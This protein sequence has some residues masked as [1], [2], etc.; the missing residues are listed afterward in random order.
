MEKYQQF[1]VEGNSILFCSGKDVCRY[2]VNV[3]TFLDH[4][5]MYATFDSERIKSICRYLLAYI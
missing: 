5:T 3:I 1:G 4:E 2:H